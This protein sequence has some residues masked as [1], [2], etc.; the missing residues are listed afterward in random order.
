MKPMFHPAIEEVTLPGIFYAL[1]DPVRLAIAHTLYRAKYPLTCTEAVEGIKELP[2]STRSHSFN[3]LRQSGLIRSEKK[4]REC[5]N[6]L[7]T[8]E[9]NTKFP[10]LLSTV[11]AQQSS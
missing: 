7:R 9:L 1:S 2:L 11:M 3:V 8:K 6:R 10:R 5:Y 4:G